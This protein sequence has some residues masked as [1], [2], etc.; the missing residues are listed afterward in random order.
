MEQFISEFCP[1]LSEDY[2]PP[3]PPELSFKNSDTLEK[4]ITDREFKAALP[5]TKKESSPGLDKINYKL[6]DKLPE[7]YKQILL[8]I[9]N[10]LM[11]EGK[12]PDS[13]RDF[14]VFLIPKPTPGKFRPI[15]LASCVLKLFEKIVCNRLNWW[16]ENEKI[17]PPSFNGFRKMKSCADNLA[18]ITTEAYTGFV[19]RE[20]T[21]AFFLDIQGAFDHVDPNELY[22]ELA[23]IGVPKH[24]ATFIYFLLAYR[25]AFI[26]VGGE[27]GGSNTKLLQCRSRGITA[28][29]TS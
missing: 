28:Y 24:I 29:K 7:S 26:V 3:P 2:T 15:T 27:L 6:I 23:D 14:L 22:E 4:K 9:F 25:R 20:Y 18:I 1:N 8:S 10:K 19:K 12:F 11:E 17:F 13:W 16:L 5:S 21:A